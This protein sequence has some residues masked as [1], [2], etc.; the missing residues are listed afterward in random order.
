MIIFLYGEDSYGISQKLNELLNRYR[1]KNPI[2]L[3]FTSLNFLE[4]SLEDLKD[5]LINTSLI[6][7]KKLIILKNIEKSDSLKLLDLIKSHNLSIREDVI[8]IAVS[9]R[10]FKNKLFEYLIKKPNQSQNFKPLKY[11]EFKNWARNFFNSFNTEITG[12]A[13]EFLLSKCGSDKWRLDSEIKKITCFNANG[14]I[15]RHQI[16]DL[17]L[18][19]N[20]HNI[21]ELTDAL[22]N[23][24]KKQALKALYKILE[25]GEKPTE[26]LGMMAWQIRNIIQFKLDSKSLKL[27]PFV[28]GKI[29]ESASLFSIEELKV[30]LLKIIDLD[31][32]FKTTDLSE[33]TAL[34][35]L[36]SDM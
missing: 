27:H 3:N 29:K 35:L 11:Y 26:I 8:L 18:V 7:E 23:K 14:L 9:F 36:I 15:N 22:A 5:N 13:L 12:E 31:L 20:N 30:G 10:D 2:G 4:N 28:L 33:K 6:P 25:N 16:E 19:N 34:S 1:I 24:N 32:A 17:I 21:F